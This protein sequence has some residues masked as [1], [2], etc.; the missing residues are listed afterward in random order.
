[1]SPDVTW[2]DIAVRLALT[3]IAGAVI[4][5]NRGEH[6]LAAGLRT[7]MLVCLAASLGDDPDQYPHCQLRQG[8]L[9]RSSRSTSCGCRWASC[10]GWALSAAA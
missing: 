8:R 4:G 9:I 5:L 6:G 7:T 2:P 10:R 3:I 1:M